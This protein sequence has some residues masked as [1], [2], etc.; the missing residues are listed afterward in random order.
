MSSNP[1]RIYFTD[2]INAYTFKYVQ[3]ISDSKEGMKA[4]VIEGNR[5]DGS[6]V[7][8]GGK[9]SQEI[10]VKGTIVQNSGYMSITSEMNDMRTKVTTNVATL[11]LQHWDGSTWANDWSYSVRRIE[12]ITFEDSLRYVDQN[13]E[14]KFLVLAY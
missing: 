9:K 13:Y 2:G 4:V 7:I 12:E 6:I 3:S 14:V 8:P 10:S 11:S 1:V 5:G